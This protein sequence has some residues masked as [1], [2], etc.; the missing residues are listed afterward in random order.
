MV[1]EYG[2]IHPGSHRRR[3]ALLALQGW[4]ICYTFSDG[5]KLCS[6]LLLS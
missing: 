3:E 4:V 1:I 2:G 6:R 5:M